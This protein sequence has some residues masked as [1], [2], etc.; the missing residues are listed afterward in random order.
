MPGAWLPP[1]PA[2]ARRSRLVNPSRFRQSAAG[3]PGN[4]LS[5]PSLHRVSPLP[6]RAPPDPAASCPGRGG[7]GLDSRTWRDTHRPR[8]GERRRDRERQGLE[9]HAGRGD[10]GSRGRSWR[11][12][13]RSQESTPP[14]PP[15]S[16]RPRGRDWERQSQP[17]RETREGDRGRDGDSAEMGGGGGPPPKEKTGASKGESVGRGRTCEN[18]YL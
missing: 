3:C 17:R 13:R 15:Q 11:K 14:P 16:Q 8:D 5:P 6:T 12:E 4:D 2:P 7:R 1:F 9:T 10:S 18:K